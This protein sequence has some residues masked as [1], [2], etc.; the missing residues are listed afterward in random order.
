MYIYLNRWSVYHRHGFQLTGYE[1]TRCDRVT[2]NVNKSSHRVFLREPL[3]FFRVN[4]TFR[5]RYH[6]YSYVRHFMIINW[7]TSREHERWRVYT[8]VIPS[9]RCSYNFRLYA[10]Y[11]TH[12]D[13]TIISLRLWYAPENHWKRIY[14]H[15]LTARR[16]KTFS[17]VISRASQVF[18]SELLIFMH[19]YT[20]GS[21]ICFNE[22]YTTIVVSRVR[23]HTFCPRFLRVGSLSFASQ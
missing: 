22:L 10:R 16:S 23:A 3:E 5:I 20:P 6:I 2:R 12:D 1:I 7:Q 8:Y 14:N 19:Y 21:R 15:L 13:Y 11:V 17:S 4:E 18:F 9:V